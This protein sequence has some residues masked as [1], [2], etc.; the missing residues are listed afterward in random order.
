MLL[1][2]ETVSLG[3]LSPAQFCEGKPVDKLEKKTKRDKTQS[4]GTGMGQWLPR[5]EISKIKPES[6]Y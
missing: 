2:R 4:G 1:G 5:K 6:A 3:Q